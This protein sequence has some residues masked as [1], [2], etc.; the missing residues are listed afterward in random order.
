MILVVGASGHLGQAAVQRLLAD[1]WQVRVMARNPSS[2]KALGQQ[3]V[4]IVQGDLRDPA[5]L[6]RACLGVDRVLAAAHALNGKGT[7]NPHTVD[8]QG[9]MRLVDA[10]KATGVSHFVFISAL[11]ASLQSPVEFFRIKYRAEEYLRSSGLKF[12]I[13][14]PSA[15]MDL[16][17]AMIGEPIMKQ[18]Q[19]S[20]F[21]SGRNPINFVAVED[22]ADLIMKVLQ[23][24][25]FIG[26]TL[27]VG[28]P[29]NLTLNQVVSIFENLSKRPVKKRYMPVTMMRAM[30]VLMRPVNPTA[31]RL[32]QLGVYMDTDDVSF[33]IGSQ[34]SAF[35][36]P[37]CRFADWAKVRYKAIREFEG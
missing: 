30:S 6:Q 23:D 1:G 13:L 28:G 17:G 33:D 8:A 36:A 25:E 35:S 11:G 31:A 19:A 27:D 21:G 37:K 3:G 7:N 10:A 34:P 32:I 24:P 4:E 20:I 5:S 18:G 22:V 26:K 9:N 14:R 16:W 29:E 2:A 12:T 15:Y